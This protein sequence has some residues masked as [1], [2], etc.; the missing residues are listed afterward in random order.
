M[1][2]TKRSRPGGSW[3]STPI[4]SVLPAIT[5][6]TGLGD[7]LTASTGTWLGQR[8][9]TFTYQWKRG[10]VAISGATS[11]TYVITVDDIATTLTVTVTATMK[12]TG[13]ASATSAG[14][15]IPQLV[16]P[17]N[18]TPPVLTGTAVSGGNVLSVTNGTWSGPPTTYAY[19]WFYSPFTSI[20]GAT[21]STYTLDGDDVGETIFCIVTAS[22][23]DGEATANSNSI[24]P[25]VAQTPSAFTF[26]D[27]TLA[28]VS[29]VYRSNLITV[30]G[31][32]AMVAVSITGGEYSKNAAP[33]TTEAGTVVAGD[34]IMVRV[35]SS[36]DHLTPVSATLT[37]FGISDTFTVITA[38]APAAPA[39]DVWDDTRLWAD[40][41]V[42]A[43]GDISEPP[44][45]DW[46]D[47]DYAII[48]VLH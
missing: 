5:G 9:P 19:E 32:D 13:T 44:G 22:N 3:A 33:Y 12:A 43:D 18:V 26:E 36:N 4:N 16:L 27:V 35:T 10:G 42:W 14:R 24:G 28:D 38:A 23:G 41:D 21:A 46:T 8:S 15:L 1:A 25:I 40:S 31:T 29:T 47:D 11:S 39:E 37:I 20:S 17:A 30:E 6:D 2:W 45:S 7:T 34:T 48:A